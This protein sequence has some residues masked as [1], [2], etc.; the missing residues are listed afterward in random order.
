MSDYTVIADIGE[1]IVQLLWNEMQQDPQVNALIDNANRISLQSPYELRNDNT[2]RLS[3]YLYRVVEDT[4]AKNR[5][6]VPGSGASLRRPPLSLD[7]Y[8]LVTPL[9]GAPREQQIVLGKT[10]QVL[11]DRAILSGADLF[12]SMA[13]S[14]DAVRIMLNTV[15]L[16]ETTRVWWSLQMSYRLSTCYAVRV[17]FVDSTRQRFTQPIVEQQSAFGESAVHA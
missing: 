7:L 9:L 14:D 6:P 5:F 15:S 2:V 10:M 16:E 4:Y 1:S 13:G 12:G 11:Y 17:A 3:I 8:Y